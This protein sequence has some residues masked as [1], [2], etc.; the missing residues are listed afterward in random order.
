MAGDDPGSGSLREPDRDPM[1]PDPDRD[2]WYLAPYGADLTD[3]DR[4]RTWPEPVEPLLWDEVLRFFPLLA[5]PPPPPPPQ[6]VAQFPIFPPQV[7]V[8]IAAITACDNLESCLFKWDLLEDP[9]DS[10]LCLTIG[11][12]WIIHL[13][14]ANPVL[15]TFGRTENYL[16]FLNI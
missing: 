16:I 9:T 13:R 10:K 1:I 7:I 11:F 15:E 5:P 3:W 4:L 8:P 6:V 14:A 2:P 12:M